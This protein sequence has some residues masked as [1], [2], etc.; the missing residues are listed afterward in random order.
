VVSS[1]KEKE[2]LLRRDGRRDGGWQREGYKVV[3]GGQ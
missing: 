2:V 1:E 3:Q